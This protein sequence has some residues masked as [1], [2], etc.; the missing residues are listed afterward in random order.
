MWNEKL[1]KKLDNDSVMNNWTKN[2]KVG[3]RIGQL[4]KQ[5]KIGQLDKQLDNLKN[6][7]KN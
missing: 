4:D 2:G 5:L 1:D 7:T 3:Q 6:W